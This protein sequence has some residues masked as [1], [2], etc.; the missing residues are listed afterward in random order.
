MATL[1]TSGLI[2]IRF[3]VDTVETLGGN[4]VQWFAGDV[5]VIDNEASITIDNTTA[6]ACMSQLARAI[7]NRTIFSKVL[8]QGFSP[9]AGTRVAS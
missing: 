7:Y 6:V 9:N 5:R 3:S 4:S 2:A 8:L 1:N